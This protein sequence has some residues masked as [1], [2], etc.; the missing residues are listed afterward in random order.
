[1]TL[2]ELVDRINAL[3][4]AGYAV[5]VVLTGGTVGFVRTVTS[6]DTPGDFGC[7]YSSGPSASEK[8]LVVVLAGVGA[9]LIARTGWSWLAAF[10][11]AGRGDWQSAQSLLDEI[12]GNRRA[13]IREAKA[14][15][16]RLL[17]ENWDWISAV[18]GLLEKERHFSGEQVAACKPVSA[19]EP[20]EQAVSLT[21]PT[22][23]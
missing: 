22:A 14:A 4:E 9:E 10:R 13:V 11:S 7:T 16:T 6:A 20:L 19:N 8:R 5:M 15:V 12:G 2:L 1:M 18:A 23:R 3:H 21:G 17:T